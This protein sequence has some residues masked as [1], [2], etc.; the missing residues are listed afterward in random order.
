MASYNFYQPNSISTWTIN[1]NLHTKFLA[2]DVM[3]LVSGGTFEKIMPESVDII[4]DNTISVVFPTPQ[5]GRA[6]VV[7]PNV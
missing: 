7:A 2:I 1:H 4:N 3:R 6:R 5:F